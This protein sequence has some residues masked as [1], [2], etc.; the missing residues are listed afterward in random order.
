MTRYGQL[1]KIRFRKSTRRHRL[2][3][4][5]WNVKK[6]LSTGNCWNR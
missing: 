1:S 5:C 3:L 2:T 4:L 6:N